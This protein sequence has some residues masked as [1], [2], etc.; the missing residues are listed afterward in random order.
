[1]QSSAGMKLAFQAN[2]KACSQRLLFYFVGLLFSLIDSFCPLG[3]LGMGRRSVDTFI[4]VG[5]LCLS[6]IERSRS[7]V[8]K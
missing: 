2:P 1:M 6:I 4:I 8:Q 3:H 5:S 7:G